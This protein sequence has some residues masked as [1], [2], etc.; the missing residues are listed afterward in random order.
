MCGGQK[1]DYKKTTES[2]ICF[3]KE[4]IKVHGIFDSNNAKWEFVE[5]QKCET[6]E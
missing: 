2:M 1:E 5:Q 3:F 6:F 4:I